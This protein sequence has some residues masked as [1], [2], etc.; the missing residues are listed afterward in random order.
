MNSFKKDLGNG[1]LSAYSYTDISNGNFLFERVFICDSD[2]ATYC[3]EIAS[4]KYIHEGDVQI[5]ACEFQSLK[6]KAVQCLKKNA[7]S[8][9]LSPV[10]SL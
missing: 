7:G 9:L 3:A 1:C 6:Y 10:F 8:A 5:C 4:N 2:I